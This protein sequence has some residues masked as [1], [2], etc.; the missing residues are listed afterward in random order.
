M[1]ICNTDAAINILTIV[2]GI[3]VKTYELG[4]IIGKL[5]HKIHVIK[6]EPI[7]VD[8]VKFTHFVGRSESGKVLFSVNC[9]IPCEIECL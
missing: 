1:S 2:T 7:F 4:G 6:R 8:D 3:G 9:L 5:E